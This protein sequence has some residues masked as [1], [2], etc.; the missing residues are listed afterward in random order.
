ML[1]S[2]KW[3]D[4]VW[5]M[6]LFL[7]SIAAIFLLFV[8]VGTSAGQEQEGVIE[9]NYETTNPSDGFGFI[10]KR[11]G[12]KLRVFL[13]SPFPKKKENI[14]EELA[15]KRLAELKYV[16]EKPDMANFE[17]ATI[18]YSTTVGMW[19]DFINK[20]KLD[21][22]KSH[23][24]KTLSKHIPVIEGLM[25][26]YDPTTAEWR[27]VKQDLDYLQIYIDKLQE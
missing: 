5:V 18:R 15:T 26:K 27:F 21:S 14:Y 20:N 16:I 1:L 3:R 17:K 10:A 22:R 19:A 2:L 24:A 12:E 25:T 9:V 23:A 7:L 4:N 11:L 8:G 6:K 13:S